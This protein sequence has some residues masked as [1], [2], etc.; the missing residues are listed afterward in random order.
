[1]RLQR[2]PCSECSSR[3]HYGAAKK[4]ELKFAPACPN[5][6]EANRPAGTREALPGTKIELRNSKRL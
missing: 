5:K 2:S 1:M 3:N 4:G 6:V